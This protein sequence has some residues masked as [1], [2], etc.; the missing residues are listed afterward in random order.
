MTRR[1]LRFFVMFLALIAATAAGGNR[2]AIGQHSAG[3]QVDSSRGL[4]MPYSDI[5]ER[6][7]SDFDCNYNHIADRREIRLGLAQDENGDSLL[8]ICDPGSLNILYRHAAARTHITGV[9]LKAHYVIARIVTSSNAP[10]RLR[11]FDANG[12]ISDEKLACG[13]R[14]TRKAA[15]DKAAIAHAVHPGDF[16][17]VV[18]RGDSVTLARAFR[19]K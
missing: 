17:I 13:R 7:F 5:D 6:Q 4:G 8:D 19:P 14:G 18:A 3:A 15:W 10:I 11:L 9:T 12:P 16:L 1:G 2:P